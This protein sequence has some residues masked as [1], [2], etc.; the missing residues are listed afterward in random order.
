MAV[1]S[2]IELPKIIV[3]RTCDSSTAIPYGTLL[4]LTADNTAIASSGDTDPFA[5]WANE[6]KSATDTDI[7]EIACALDG[8][9][10]QDTTAAA[11]AVGQMV[12]IGGAN[13]VILADSAAWV[14]GSVVGKAEEARDGSNRIR[15]RGIGI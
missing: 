9:W 10:D 1:A 2:N 3:R 7:T 12:N 8:V 11:I 13:T 14:A 15:V 5:G 6:E 4:K